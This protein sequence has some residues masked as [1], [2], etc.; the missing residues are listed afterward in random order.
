MREAVKA[1]RAFVKAPAWSDYI[2]SEF[3]EFANATTDE[4]LDA[5]I[6]NNTSTFDHPVGSV[7]MGQGP[8]GALNADLTVKGTVGLRVVDAS[9][10][11][12]VT[13]SLIR[14][15]RVW[16]QVADTFGI[17]DSLSSLRGIHKVR[18]ISWRSG[19]R[20]LQR[21]ALAVIVPR[22]VASVD[23]TEML[24]NGR[25]IGLYC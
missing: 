15:P 11:V 9:A 21:R 1:A 16:Y 20:H 8:E 10:F 13:F 24:V 22:E 4:A 14:W 2:I 17:I 7:R 18:R 25:M 6:R 19:Q 23:L 12:S 5:Y 3:G